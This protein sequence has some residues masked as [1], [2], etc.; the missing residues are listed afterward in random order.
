MHD[1]MVIMYYSILSI[2]VLLNFLQVIAYMNFYELNQSSLIV[3][4]SM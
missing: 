1:C 2:G 4:Y 3:S